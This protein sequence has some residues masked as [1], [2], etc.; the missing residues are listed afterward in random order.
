MILCPSVAR[1][2]Q[3]YIDNVC[4]GRPSGL[5][6]QEKLPYLQAM[7]KE[8]LR[9]KPVTAVGVPH[10]AEEVKDPFPDY[11]D[12]TV[13][14]GGGSSPTTPSIDI[15]SLRSAFEFGPGTNECGNNILPDRGYVPG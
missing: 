9:W 13:A 8:V 15:A 4:A 7:V 2:S 14:Y 5:E 1:T 12:D 6:D 3:A 11:H 10:V